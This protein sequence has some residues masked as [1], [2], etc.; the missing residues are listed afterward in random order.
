MRHQ[1][2]LL[3]AQLD[4]SASWAGDLCVE[5]LGVGECD[6]WRGCIMR[7]EGVEEGWSGHLGKESGR[8]KE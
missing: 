2:A 4:L 6:K 7:Y 3:A 5:R 1:H 8:V